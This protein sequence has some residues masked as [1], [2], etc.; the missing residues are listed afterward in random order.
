MVSSNFIT[1][2][3]SFLIVSALVY[4]KK[5][6][7]RAKIDIRPGWGHGISILNHKRQVF[8][9]TRTTLAFPSP[10]EEQ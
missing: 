9:L 4:F 1:L 10:H 3:P 5:K 7:P 6:P 2:P 8:W